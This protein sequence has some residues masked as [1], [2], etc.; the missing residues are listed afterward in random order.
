MAGG[1]S[2]GSSR[3]YAGAHALAA[4]FVAR[5]AYRSSSKVMVQRDIRLTSYFSSLMD[6]REA[7]L[8]AKMRLSSSLHCFDTGR[9]DCKKSGLD[10]YARKVSSEGHACFHGLRPQVRLTSLLG[11]E[12]DGVEISVAVR[13]KS[14]PDGR[15]IPRDEGLTSHPKTRHRCARSSRTPNAGKGL[16]G[17]L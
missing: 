15:A 4:S 2:Q 8:S 16:P 5:V 3:M 9:M 6:I 17:T 10:R 1:A 12:G 11:Q 14:G 7:G 13:T